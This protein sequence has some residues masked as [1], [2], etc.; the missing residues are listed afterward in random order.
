MQGSVVPK[1]R[2]DT[3]LVQKGLSTTKEKARALVLSGVVRVSG[4][5]VHKPGT[6]VE[7]GSLLEV[8]ET[9][10]HVSR[11]G[12]KLA[13]ALDF[14]DLDL[15]RLVAGDIGAS[16]GGFTPC[17]LKRGVERVY[18]VDVGYGQLDYSLR[19]D[20]RV[21]VM[22]RTNA[23]YPLSIPEQLNLFTVDVSFISLTKVLPSLLPLLKPGG[24]MVTL[25]KPQFEAG[26]DRIERGG[27]VRNPG[28]HAEV[29]GAIGLWA[30]KTGIRVRDL[31][32][33]PILGPAGNREFFLLLQAPF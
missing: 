12:V 9:R 7:I 24:W 28:V 21:V 33:S 14:F 16:T 32:P 27:V 3:L 4:S 8:A 2:L 20:P 25:V 6:P 22:E 23:R 19:I 31:T 11:G 30:I 17:L 13:S 29:L 18:A 5:V 10:T 1:D 26:R 15:H